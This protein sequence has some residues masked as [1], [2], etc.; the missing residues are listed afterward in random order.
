MRERPA[1]WLQ[2]WWGRRGKGVDLQP[3]CLAYGLKIGSAFV[4]VIRSAH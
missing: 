3:T 4:V 2:L 1:G